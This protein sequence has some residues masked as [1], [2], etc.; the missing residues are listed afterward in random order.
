MAYQYHT[1]SGEGVGSSFALLVLQPFV[2]S[3]TVVTRAPELGLDSN[4]AA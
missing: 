2:Q 1:E 4:G 3:A